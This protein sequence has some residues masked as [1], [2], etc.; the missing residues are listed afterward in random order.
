MSKKLTVDEFFHKHADIGM[1]GWIATDEGEA[2][3]REVEKLESGQT[4]LEIGVAYGKSLSLA[5]YYSKPGV[6]IWGIDRLNWIQRE[7]T[8]DKLELEKEFNFIE[9]ESQWEAF[10]W[11]K[12][13][14]LLFIDGDH[15]YYGIIKDLLSWLPHVKHGGRVMLHDYDPSSPGVVRAVHEF[16]EPHP[17]YKDVQKDRSI[18]SFTKI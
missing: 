4:Y 15:T 12:P 2:L 16:I 11:Q 6:D 3:R 7:E 18:Y 1:D 13:L 8:F 17:A 9:G 10:K 14:D 5:C